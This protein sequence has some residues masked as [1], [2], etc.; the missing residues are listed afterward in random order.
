MACFIADSF[1]RQ[2]AETDDRPDSAAL[3]GRYLS[4][5]S[6]GLLS[7]QGALQGRS[8]GRSI[9]GGTN[10]AGGPPTPPPHPKSIFLPL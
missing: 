10:T 8:Q 2:R 5:L 4:S 6:C 1:M 9:G 3:Q 7:L